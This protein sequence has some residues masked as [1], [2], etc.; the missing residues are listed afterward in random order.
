[1]TIGIQAQLDLFNAVFEQFEIVR[2]SGSVDWIKEITSSSI[3]NFTWEEWSKI[4]AIRK[5]PTINSNDFDELRRYAR[6][7][8]LASSP[9]TREE[10]NGKVNNWLSAHADAPGQGHTDA[11]QQGSTAGSRVESNPLLNVTPIKSK[12]GDE[13]TGINS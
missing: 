13:P 6:D 9:E 5:N 8:A 11:A 4:I 1:L 7:R 2:N 3:G 12:R 10:A